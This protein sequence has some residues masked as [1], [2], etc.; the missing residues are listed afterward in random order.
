MEEKGSCLGL[1]NTGDMDTE[2]VRHVQIGC[3][4]CYVARGLLLR[5]ILRRWFVLLEK[6]EAA[7]LKRDSRYSISV[8]SPFHD[9]VSC[10]PVRAQDRPRFYLEKGDSLALLRKGTQ[11]WTTI[12]PT[13]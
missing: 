10:L 7:L 3:S 4:L 9:R 1:G 2:G 8:Y 6:L 5:R 11:G 13:F 12:R